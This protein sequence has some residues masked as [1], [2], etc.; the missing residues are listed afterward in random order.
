M[1]PGLACG[2]D[3]AHLSLFGYPPLPIYRGRGA[4]EALG[5]GLRIRK[6][7]VAFKCNFAWM[8]SHRRVMRRCPGTGAQMK[9]VAME[10]ARRMDGMIVEDVEVGV[11][12]TGEHR[13]VI[14]LRGEGLI[15]AISNTDPL[16]DGLPLGEA[17][18]LAEGGAKC[19]RIVNKVS[20]KMEQICNDW[21]GN[22]LNGIHPGVNVILFRGAAEGLDLETFDVRHGINA[23]LIAPTK[24]IA[25]VGRAVGLQLLDVEGATG[26]YDTNLK[27]KGT[28]CIKEMMKK[29]ENGEWKWSMGIVHVK[30]VD[31]AVRLHL[32]LSLI[33][34]L[35]DENIN[36]VCLYC[37]VVCLT[38]C[39]LRAMNRMWPVSVTG[40]ETW[41]RCCAT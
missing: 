37:I 5:A 40:C 14:R 38:S 21:E 26:G 13:C 17:K 2:S 32:D 4:L 29:N 6:G 36:N 28:R 3:T 31:E 35:C 12:Y 34:D 1:S 20:K 9:Y 7:D 24:I 19:A 39:D 18:K 16:V 8:D 10:L 41:M 30:A 22:V 15:D 11:L 33:I 23:F 27:M 25:G